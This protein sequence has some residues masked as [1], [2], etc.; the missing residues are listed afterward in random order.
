MRLVAAWLRLELRRRWRPLLVLALLIAISAGT[1][2]AAVAGARRGASALDRLL[3]VTLPASAVVLP[4]QPGFNW[5]AVRALP[6][7]EAV[8]TFPVSGFE[9]EGIPREAEASTF[10]LDA[11]AMSTLERPVVLDGR[12][13]D[14]GRLDEVVVTPRFVESY[15]RGVGDSATLRLFQ[16]ELIDQAHGDVDTLPG[17]GPSIKVRIVGVVRSFWFADRPGSGGGLIPSAALFARY[18]PNLIGNSEVGFINALVR[19][20]GGPAALP[21]FRAELARLT[22]RSDIEMF[23]QGAEALKARKATGFE[24]ANLLAFALAVLAAAIVLVGQALARYVAGAVGDL[25]VLLAIGMQR[26]HALLAALAG[27]VL[28]ALVGVAAGVGGAIVASAWL[29][30]GTPALVEPAPGIDV[31]PLVLGGGGLAL[32]LLVITGSAAAGWLVITS[33]DRAAPCRSA[34][35]ATAARAG[36]PVAVLVGARFALEP[37]RGR[38]RCRCARR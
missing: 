29:P 2:L 14:P 24:A 23:D 7:V 28:A 37:G 19:L 16:P 13:A 3:E 26:W 21:A 11:N 34:I 20:R 22:G 33:R 36:L 18:R 25:Q 4:N 38:P 30:F 6:D 12:L 5:D 9:I 1:V 15:G 17:D 31:D 10:P 35:A 27:P 32:L 8:A